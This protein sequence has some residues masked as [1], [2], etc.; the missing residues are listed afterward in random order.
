MESTQN[1]IINDLV[2]EFRKG[3]ILAELGLGETYLDI[4][5]LRPEIQEII[6]NVAIDFDCHR[7]KVVIAAIAA[8][9]AV[10][11]KKAF[12]KYK[13]FTNRCSVYAMI[14]D[15]K[16]GIK[17]S[18]IKYMM[19]PVEKIDKKCRDEYNS[20][21]M[22]SKS[23][24]I[25]APLSTIL[26]RGSTSEE[27]HKL[28]G[29]SKAGLLMW[30]DEITVYFK[31][32]GKY[33]LRKDTG[34]SQEDCSLFDGMSQAPDRISDKLKMSSPN[35]AY[36]I[37]G[38]TTTPTFAE[39]FKPFF[40][41]ETGEYD[42]YL[43]VMTEWRKRKHEENDEILRADDIVWESVINELY[44]M[45]ANQ[46]YSL[47]SE[48]KKLYVAY[49]NR[50]CI[51]AI[52]SDPNY[53]QFITGYKQ[54]NAHYLIRLSLIFHILNDW[55]NPVISKEEMEMTIRCMRVFNIYA[56]NC[57]NL[58]IN[59]NTKEVKDISA[60]EIVRDIYKYNNKM[61]RSTK[62]INQSE[63]ARNL[64]ISQ[65]AVAKELKKL[66]DGGIIVESKE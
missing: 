20:K 35:V 66:K 49:K 63:I 64:D 48:A 11:G 52:N 44:S 57:Y 7:D 3:E 55:R 32:R 54:R 2:S 22:A 14:V 17:S 37:I 15:Y 13:H 1:N 18:V 33:S 46:E 40:M 27:K 23:D 34:E 43:Y 5:S 59:S 45:P 6:N 53:T 61:G 38:S 50:E 58:V 10:V 39:N 21:L 25:I 31:E 30:K 65:A 62:K 26:T 9:C 41:A 56:E 47:D 12:V 8:V 29:A 36:S 4:S 28:L 24:D 42:R 16:G 51:D 60:S 19:S